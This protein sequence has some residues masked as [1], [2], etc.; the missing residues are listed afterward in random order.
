MLDAW[1]QDLE[2]LEAITRS[3]DAREIFLKMAALM[4]A[5]RTPSLLAEL[6]RDED[7][8][9][10]TKGHVTELAQDRDFLVAVEE[11]LRRTERLH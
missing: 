8:D 2:S 1:L 11:Y 7:I 6:E 9:E 10:A 4:H 5:G 3:D